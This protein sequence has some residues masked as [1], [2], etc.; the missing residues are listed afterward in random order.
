[1]VVVMVVV[2][3]EA[4][5]PSS[6]RKK[7]CARCTKGT[8]DERYPNRLMIDKVYIRHKRINHQSST[9]YYY[10]NYYYTHF[11]LHSLLGNLEGRQLSFRS[12][13]LHQMLLLF[14]WKRALW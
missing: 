5:V 11:S 14:H 4:A 1:V 10:Y 12:F 7:R 9:Y 6:G 8:N 13:L 2:V 3:V